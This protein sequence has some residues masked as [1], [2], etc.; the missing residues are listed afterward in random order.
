MANKYIH[1]HIYTIFWEDKF[2]GVIDDSRVDN[3]YNNRGQG[4]DL[5][6]LS[7]FEESLLVADLKK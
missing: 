4:W 5:K 2:T 6:Y 7:I 1:T 3:S